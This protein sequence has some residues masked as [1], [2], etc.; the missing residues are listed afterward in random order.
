MPLFR[1]RPRPAPSPAGRRPE[2]DR[3]SPGSLSR[4]LGEEP[5]WR[6]Y[7]SVA[8]TYARIHAPRLAVVAADLV[9]LAGPAPD[10]RVLDLGTGT[11]VAARAAAATALRGLVVGVDASLGMLALARAEGGGPRYAAAQAIDLPFR[12]DT[13]DLVLA[14]FVLGHFTKLDTALFEVLRVLRPAGRM[15]AS[16]WAGDPDEFTAAWRSVAEEFAGREILDSAARE[17]VPQE[18]A[19]GDPHRLEEVL[20][21]A[22]L[23]DLRVERGEYR[24]EVSAEDYLTGREI[25]AT[26][27]FLRE[28]LGPELWEAFRRRTREVFAE[29]F[30]P[31]FNDFRQVNLAVGRKP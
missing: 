9:E 13:F 10:A 22:G 20:R 28:T 16:T 19:L 23:R 31:A 7:D 18:E 5:D 11:G 29:R 14:N 27:R 4:L 21:D 3:G 1:R 24:F 8:P 2:S 17:A 25:G 6:S 12:D 26:G 15:A 30:P